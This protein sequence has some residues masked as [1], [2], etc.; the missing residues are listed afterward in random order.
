MKKRIKK[1]T[2][3]KKVSNRKLIEKLARDKKKGSK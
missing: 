3:L 1:N 2:G